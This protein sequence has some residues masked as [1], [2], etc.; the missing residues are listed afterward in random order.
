M[1]KNDTVE[2]AV[3]SNAFYVEI[4]NLRSRKGTMAKRAGTVVKTVVTF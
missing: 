3:W 2:G 4:R 1:L